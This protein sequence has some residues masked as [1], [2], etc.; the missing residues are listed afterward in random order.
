[1]TIYPFGSWLWQN[2]H[3]RSIRNGRN[4]RESVWLCRNQVRKWVNRT[5]NQ[6]W[7]SGGSLGLNREYSAEYS[8]CSAVAKDRLGWSGWRLGWISAYAA[9]IWLA[10]TTL[11]FFLWSAWVRL[12]YSY[13][14]FRRRVW[15]TSVSDE[16]DS[17]VSE[18]VWMSYTRWNDQN[19][20]LTTLKI[21]LSLKILLFS[22]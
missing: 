4:S 14:T 11:V 18:F 19:L 8:I 21:R 9:R 1:M 12:G 5:Q 16:A 15:A 13:I 20:F 10:W 3:C 7:A 17:C 6:F 2:R 22:D